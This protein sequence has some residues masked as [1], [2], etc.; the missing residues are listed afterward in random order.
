M[1]VHLKKILSWSS[2]LVYGDDFMVNNYTAQIHFVTNTSDIQAQNIAYERIK[3]WVDIM[4][5]AIFIHDQNA[6]V[7]SY[8]NI[9]ARLI[10]LPVEPVDQIIGIMLYLKLNAITED[11]LVVMDVEIS[12]DKGDGMIYLHDHKEPTLESMLGDS[13]C[14]DPRPVWDNHKKRSGGK[15]VNLGRQSEWKD[16]DLAW[17]AKNEPGAGVV[18]AQFGKNEDQ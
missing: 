11:R 1:N 13:W 16:H 2:G 4:D 8:S 5:D 10:P 12:S 9:G 18:F 7:K 6:L 14:S 17:E 3:A 15:I